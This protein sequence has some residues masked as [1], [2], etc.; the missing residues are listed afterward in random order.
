MLLALERYSIV[1]ISLMILLM[2]EAVRASRN[3]QW[4]HDDDGTIISSP[5]AEVGVRVAE[6]VRQSADAAS[7][8]RYEFR[9]EA[10]NTNLRKWLRKSAKKGQAVMA[11]LFAVRIGGEGGVS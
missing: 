3:S 2:K 1:T 5:T 9:P 6:V 7:D 4:S 11:E 10:D 8:V